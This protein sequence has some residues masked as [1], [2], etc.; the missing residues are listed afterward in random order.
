MN[1]VTFSEALGLIVLMLPYSGNQVASN[2]YIQRA[3]TL[4]GKNI[5]C[6]LHCEILLDSRLMNY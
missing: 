1:A 4:A 3:I 5:D 6:R 2:T